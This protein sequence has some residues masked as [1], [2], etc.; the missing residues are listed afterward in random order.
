M[1]N[2]EERNRGGKEIGMERD[3]ELDRVECTIVRFFR[4]DL[5]LWISMVYISVARYTA[6]VT[7][8]NLQV[9]GIELS[10]SDPLESGDDLPLH[11][12]VGERG[13][14]FPWAC[15]SQPCPVD[16]R[17]MHDLSLVYSH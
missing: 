3:R 7:K 8:S 5:V 16:R 10:D 2:S 6:R 14:R 12:G 11:G 13:T 1:G 15:L 4:D 9:L 17:S